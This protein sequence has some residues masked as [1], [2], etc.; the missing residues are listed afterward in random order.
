MANG[1][2]WSLDERYRANRQRKG[3]NVAFQYT[4]CTETRNYGRIR[5]HYPVNH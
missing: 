3:T 1:V 5:L 2:N 4:R